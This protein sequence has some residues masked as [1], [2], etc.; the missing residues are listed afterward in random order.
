MT[1]HARYLQILPLLRT[2]EVGVSNGPNA[3]IWVQTENLHH[4]QHAILALLLT[5][6]SLLGLEEV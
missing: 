1:N 2:N 5:D 4:V 6:G 3:V